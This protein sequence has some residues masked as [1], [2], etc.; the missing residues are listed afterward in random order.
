MLERGRSVVGSVRTMLKSTTGSYSVWRLFGRNEKICKFRFALAIAG[1]RVVRI[2]K[3]GS[4]F[5][6]VF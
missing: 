1:G 4:A 5:I 6:Y 2:L 3:R